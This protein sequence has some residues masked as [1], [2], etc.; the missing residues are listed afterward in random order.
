MLLRALFIVALVALVTESIVHAAAALADA[1]LHVR[2]AAA[3]R[4]AYL[5]AAASAQRAVAQE[6]RAGRDPSLAPVPA[7]VATCLLADADGCALT[8]VATIASP[9]PSPSAAPAPC[10]SSACAVLLQ[11]NSAVRESRIAFHLRAAVSGRDG[12]LLATREGDVHL[13]TFDSPPYVALAGALDGSLALRANGTGDDG[14]VSA[15]SATTLVTVEYRAPGAVPLAGNVWQRRDEHAPA[16][17][18]AW[19]P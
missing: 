6:M 17:A 12:V 10:G 16:Q 19:D 7:P 14:G 13:R 3:A 18:P 5:A 1:A 9:T 15:P 4:T 8:V 2:A 11:A